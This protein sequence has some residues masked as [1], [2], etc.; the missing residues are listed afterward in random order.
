MYTLAQ[1]RGNVYMMQSKIWELRVKILKNDFL[2]IMDRVDLEVAP[3]T[4]WDAVGVQFVELQ[5]T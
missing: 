4:V 1:S 3:E 2:I 5:R